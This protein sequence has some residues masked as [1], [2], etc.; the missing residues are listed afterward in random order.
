[1]STRLSYGRSALISTC[2]YVYTRTR[3][4]LGGLCS[5]VGLLRRSVIA[6][7]PGMAGRWAIA[8]RGGGGVVEDLSASSFPS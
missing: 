6:G 1:M 5:A 4:G 7:R 2:V 3:R 8:G